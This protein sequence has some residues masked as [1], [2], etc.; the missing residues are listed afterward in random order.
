MI[1]SLLICELYVRPLVA[2]G[3]TGSSV[4]KRPVFCSLS[5]KEGLT[6]VLLVLVFSARMG[7]VVGL[8]QCRLPVCSC[9][10]EDAGRT[11]TVNTRGAGGQGVHAVPPLL[12]RST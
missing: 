7:S 9:E 2:G 8:L 1:A 11:H 6:W 4:Q 5:A 10:L 3:E 12:T